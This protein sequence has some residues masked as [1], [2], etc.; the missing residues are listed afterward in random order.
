MKCKSEILKNEKIL[1]VSGVSETEIERAEKLL[2]VE[3][4]NEY[5]K[6][7]KNFGV[8]SGESVEIFGLGV[9]EDS[10]LNVIRRTLDLRGED[11]FPSDCVV[12][13][14][15]DDGHFVLCSPSCCLYEWRSPNFDK[16]IIPILNESFEDY[17]LSQVSR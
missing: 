7:L 4:C 12:I 3:M 1:H 15:L 10:Y 16:K 6:F 8:I 17:L 2:G 13:Q 11:G 14:D 5:K 9:R